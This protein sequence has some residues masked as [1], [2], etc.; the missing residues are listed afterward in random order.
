MNERCENYERV[1][2]SLL[3]EA[4]DWIRDPEFEP[5]AGIAAHLTDL[6]QRILSA[7]VPL[8]PITQDDMAWARAQFAQRRN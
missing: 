4:F 2:A 3:M 1:L 5:D 8:A 7:V 6:R